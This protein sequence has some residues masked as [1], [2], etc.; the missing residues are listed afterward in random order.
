MREK[1][2]KQKEVLAQFYSNLA[3]VIMTAGIITPLYGGVT[4]AALFAIQL[5]LSILGMMVFLQIS[6][7]FLK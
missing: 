3:L 7:D 6:L 5:L 4:N 2:L 1:N